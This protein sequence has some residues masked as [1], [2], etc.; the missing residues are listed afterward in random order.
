MT[1]TLIASADRRPQICDQCGADE[2]GCAV[3]LH[4]GGKPCCDACGHGPNA[5]G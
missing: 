3:K 5:D 4:L 2:M 1:A